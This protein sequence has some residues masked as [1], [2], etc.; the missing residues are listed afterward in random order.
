MTLTGFAS[1]FENRIRATQVKR[2][3]MVRAGNAFGPVKSK[4]S[5]VSAE[6]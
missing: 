5:E 3:F 6:P 4:L 1:G 2:G